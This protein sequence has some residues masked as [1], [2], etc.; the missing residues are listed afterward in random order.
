VVRASLFLHGSS[1][2][3]LVDASGRLAARLLP[4]PNEVAHLAAGV[5]FITEYGARHTV[6]AR[7]VVIQR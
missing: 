6:R 7:K 3:S 5:Y 1:G 4:G 2:A